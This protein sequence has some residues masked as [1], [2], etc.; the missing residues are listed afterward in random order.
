VDAETYVQIPTPWGEKISLSLAYAS[1]WNAIRT[2][3]TENPY[4]LWIEQAKAWRAGYEA[5]QEVTP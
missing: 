1:G 3:R 2:G 5:R 4:P